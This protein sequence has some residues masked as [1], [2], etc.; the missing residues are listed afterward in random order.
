MCGAEVAAR[1]CARFSFNFCVHIRPLLGNF[2]VCSLIA[3]VKW[4]AAALRVK[5]NP[6]TAT[7]SIHK[8]RERRNFNRK[9]KSK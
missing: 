7:I 8:S 2:C 4:Q 3:G 5:E 9:V 6:S 1:G